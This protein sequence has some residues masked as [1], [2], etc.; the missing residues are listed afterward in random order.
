[1]FP[2]PMD[3]RFVMH[4]GQYV[5]GKN[6]AHFFS[7]DKDPEDSARSVTVS[8][9]ARDYRCYLRKSQNVINI[10]R[11]VVNKMVRMSIRD[12]EVAALA[13]IILWNEGRP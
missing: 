4:Y 2:D 7:E 13:G 9:Y 12:V 5:D 3:S 11:N 10:L 6:M 8:E 1:M